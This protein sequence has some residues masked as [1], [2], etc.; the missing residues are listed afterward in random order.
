M[1]CLPDFQQDAFRIFPPLTIPE[2]QYLNAF[3]AQIF[4]PPLIMVTLCR[5]AVFKP[6]QFN[7]QS[8]KRT[9]EVQIITNDRV[10]SAKLE[11]RKPPGPERAPQRRFLTGLL[12]AQ[13]PGVVLG[14]HI[15]WLTR[16]SG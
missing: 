5:Q 6:V 15:V 1:Q 2:S 13:T 14:I 3:P 11:A 9:I 7:R 8:C 12:S 16:L 4:G 10:L